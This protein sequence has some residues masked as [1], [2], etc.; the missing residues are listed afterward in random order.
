MSKM[1]KISKMFK[2][3]KMPFNPLRRFTYKM[4]RSEG[5]SAVIGSGNDV[6]S[7]LAGRKHRA[8][9]TRYLCS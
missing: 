7:L 5:S 4:F 6:S 2:M 1:S 8:E 9:V 3:F